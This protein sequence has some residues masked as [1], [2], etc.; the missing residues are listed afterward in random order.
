MSD[1]N[2]GLQFPM[3]LRRHVTLYKEE[4]SANYQCVQLNIEYDSSLGALDIDM[5]QW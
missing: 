3:I 2:D 1:H 4:D 5:V